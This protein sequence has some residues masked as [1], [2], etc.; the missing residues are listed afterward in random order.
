[1][2]SVAA[3]VVVGIIGFALTAFI[4]RLEMWAPLIASLVPLMAFVMWPARDETAGDVRGTF[5][6]AA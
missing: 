5:N 4:P 2:K 6:K 3:V 1:M